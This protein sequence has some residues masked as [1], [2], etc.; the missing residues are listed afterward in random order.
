MNCFISNEI[1]FVLYGRLKIMMND[2]AVTQTVANKKRVKPKGL[3]RVSYFSFNIRKFIT[4]PG[5]F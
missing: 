5:Q 4:P 2:E 3:N 1:D